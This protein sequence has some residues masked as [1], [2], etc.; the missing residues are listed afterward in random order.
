MD[1]LRVYDAEDLRSLP[2][3]IWGIK[4]PQFRFREEQPRMKG[5]S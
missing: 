4:E 1:F 5:P 2:D 3:G